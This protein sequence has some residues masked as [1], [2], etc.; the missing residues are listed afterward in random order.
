MSKDTS[1]IFHT[2]IQPLGMDGSI[3]DRKCVAFRRLSLWMCATISVKWNLPQFPPWRTHYP[4]SVNHQRTYQYEHMT[5]HIR[6]LDTSYK[7]VSFE[8]VYRS[9]KYNM[10]MVVSGGWKGREHDDVIKWRH[11]PRYWLF[12]WGI[13]RSPGNSPH[14]GQ[15]CGALI[16]SLI[17][18]W[19]NGWVN[20]REAGD[21]GRHGPIITS[22]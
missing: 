4:P 11:F 6:V 12:V 7:L 17:C 9:V 3:I 8:C 22:L 13:H 5:V 18:A 2:P 1:S 21:L 14:K 20:N 15:G 16:F 19:I 10:G